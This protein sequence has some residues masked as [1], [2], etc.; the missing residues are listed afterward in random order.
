MS[1]YGITKGWYKYY[2]GSYEGNSA[3]ILVNVTK[4]TPKS[5]TYELYRFVDED[6]DERRTKIIDDYNF[7]AVLYHKDEYKKVWRSNSDIW[8]GQIEIP[9]YILGY[10]I[11]IT[12]DQS[13]RYILDPEGNWIRHGDSIIWRDD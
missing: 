2:R 13:H 5:A 7:D 12:I 4:T 6:E 11:Y 10:G 3:G 8:E 9:E 1:T